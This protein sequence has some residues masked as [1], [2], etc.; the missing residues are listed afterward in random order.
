MGQWVSNGK[1]D[2]LGRTVVPRLDFSCKS[3]LRRTS[4]LICSLICSR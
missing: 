2:L 3:I 1:G 4:P